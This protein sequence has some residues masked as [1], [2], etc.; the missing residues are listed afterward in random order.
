MVNAVE[1]QSW[2]FRWASMPADVQPLRVMYEC[3][4]AS[5]LGVGVEF[6]RPRNRERKRTVPHNCSWNGVGITRTGTNPMA[7]EPRLP[8]SFLRAGLARIS[9]IAP[10]EVRVRGA[11]ERRHAGH[12]RRGGGLAS[13]GDGVAVAA[14]RG[15]ARRAAVLLGKR[16]CQ[17]QRQRS[18][19]WFGLDQVGV[20]N[21][22]LLEHAVLRDPVVR[23]AL[24]DADLGDQGW[25]SSSR[26]GA[27]P[28][29]PDQRGAVAVGL[30]G[31]RPREQ[32]LGA[33]GT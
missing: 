24:V 8:A 21:E 33:S 4:R 12:D 10:G 32:R 13:D 25:A 14:V 3:R 5:R 22:V 16:G 17:R 11:Y 6:N 28:I 29:N 30:D 23:E 1:Q 15:R 7:G 20:G 27:A 18:E 31:S 2:H 19:L 26:R 9:D